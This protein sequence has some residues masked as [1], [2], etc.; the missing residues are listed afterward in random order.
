MATKKTEQEA[1]TGAS[2]TTANQE[3][4]A[5]QARAA[6]LTDE[7]ASAKRNAEAV[8]FSHKNE[9]RRLEQLV[10]T[11]QGQLHNNA[12]KQKQNEPAAPVTPVSCL[13]TIIAKLQEVAIGGAA[14]DLRLTV[15][16][17]AAQITREDCVILKEYT[18]RLR[19]A[20]DAVDQEAATLLL[21]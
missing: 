16:H 13:A 10:E 11:L 2:S 21:I 12:G 18:S 4:E 8:E 19:G 7:L 15:H 1:V 3:L 17:V 20:A 6:S 14:A 9:I 5:A